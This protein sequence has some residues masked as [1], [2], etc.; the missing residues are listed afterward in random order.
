MT[1]TEFRREAGK[2][3]INPNLYAVTIDVPLPT[4]ERIQVFNGKVIGIVWFDEWKA[5]KE[6]GRVSENGAASF[7]RRLRT[8]S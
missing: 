3:G 6:Y 2:A 8:L 1:K 7:F 4:R 5:E